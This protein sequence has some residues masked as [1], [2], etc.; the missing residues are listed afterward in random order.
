LREGANQHNCE[1]LF[2]STAAAAFRVVQAFYLMRDSEV[3]KDAEL[4]PLYT[5][6]QL[7]KYQT[8]IRQATRWLFSGDVAE[9]IDAAATHE[10]DAEFGNVMPKKRKA[11]KVYSSPTAR[12]ETSTHTPNHLHS[13]CDVFSCTFN[14]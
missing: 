4:K 3:Q 11:S 10:D 13:C 5:Q 7:S 1:D 12:K 6:A 2:A 8:L 9:K 14:D